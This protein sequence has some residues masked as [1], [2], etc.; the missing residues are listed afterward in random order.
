[1]VNF[2]HVDMVRSLNDPHLVARVQEFF[3]VKMVGVVKQE[4]QDLSKQHDKNLRT[5]KLLNDKKCLYTVNNV[6]I[7]W[8]FIFITHV[9]NEIF[10]IVGLPVMSWLYDQEKTYLTTLSWA[11]V[12]YMGQAMKDLI[13][14][15]RPQTPPVV[16]MEDRYLLEYGFPSTHAMAIFN[17]SL[18]FTYLFWRDFNTDE[19]FNMRIIV[20]LV[21]LLITLSV[22]L[23]RVYLGM[24]S[25]LD[26]LG[27]VLFSLTFGLVFL[28]FSNQILWFGKQG[29]TNGLFQSI[30]F[31]LACLKYP[32]R[33][34]WSPAR[35]DTFLIMGVA[36]G[37]SLALGLKT[38]LNCGDMGKY[39]FKA[40]NKMIY[41]CFMRIF[42][43]IL[44]VLAARFLSKQYF[45]FMVKKFYSTKQ[46]KTV[47]NLEV[48]E[49]IKTKF[50]L[51]IFYYTFCYSCVSFSAMF[52]ADFLFYTLKIY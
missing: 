50:K 31:V 51:E 4:N 22:C 23:S 24:H 16:K 45:Y 37:I 34:R 5:V 20:A 28:R 17:I 7:Y 42:V 9:G 2:S 19:Y 46:F 18:S 13:K 25:L 21:A 32:C 6:F 48:K 15:P 33:D 41:I 10:Y 47:S 40:D 35:A 1:M 14:L 38:S 43:G 44:P 30:L 8:F 49:F 11:I 36:V 12:M 3:G 27:G 39:E 26:I 52:I 29:I